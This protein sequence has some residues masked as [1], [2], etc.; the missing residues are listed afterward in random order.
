M[1]A[2]AALKFPDPG[3]RPNDEERGHIVVPNRKPLAR[4]SSSVSSLARLGGFDRG[5]KI[6]RAQVLDE[7]R[8]RFLLPSPFGL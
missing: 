3:A 7:A 4:S 1:I 2:F 8:A 6:F 5:G